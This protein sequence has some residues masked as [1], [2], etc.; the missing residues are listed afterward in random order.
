MRIRVFFAVAVLAL[1]PTPSFSQVPFVQVVALNQQTALTAPNQFAKYIT[2]GNRC[3]LLLDKFF[4]TESLTGKFIV[5]LTVTFNSADST[6]H[7]PLRLLFD[8]LIEVTKTSDQPKTLKLSNIL[9]ARNIP[10][11]DVSD[12]DVT[13]RLFPVKNDSYN[14]LYSVVSPLLGQAIY[15][16]PVDLVAKVFDKFIAL[17]R[18]DDKREPLQF[19]AN[20]P[21]AQNVIEAQQI[22]R[23]GTTERLPLYN[24]Y[25]YPIILEGSKEIS[26]D[27]LAGK[28]KD[29]LNG[30]SMFF[31]GKTAIARPKSAYRGFVTIWFTKDE[32]QVLPESIIGQLKELSNASQQSE[33]DDSLKELETRVA[34]AFRAV[35]ALRKG[36]QIDDRG[37]FHLR[38]YIDLTRLWGEYRRAVTEGEKGL[39]ERNNW[40]FRF[41]DWYNTMDYVGA[42]HLTQAVGVTQIYGERL[43]KVFVPYSLTDEMTVEVMA[44]QINLHQV[45]QKLGDAGLSLS[46]S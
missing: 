43:A 40:S 29:F 28:A 30:V 16:V 44:K 8:D 15:G 18:E 17:A 12:I 11:I 13:I 32:N 10:L 21:V 35:D 3:G 31:S 25:Y 19:R 7:P 37:E 6:S 20:I 5:D 38:R 46:K 33:T 2:R 45:L 42:V 23:P 14:Q 9:L 26:D 24:N 41:R 34:D 27:S 36:K 39:R 4:F 1:L 22:D